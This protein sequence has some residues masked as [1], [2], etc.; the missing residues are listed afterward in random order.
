M[1][2][3][4]DSAWP[5]VSLGA[6]CGVALAWAYFRTRLAQQAGVLGAEQAALKERLAAT[7]R[8]RDDLRRRAQDL[9]ERA[10]SLQQEIG[11]LKISLAE[12]RGAAAEKLAIV[13]QAGQSLRD[14]FRALSAETL[15]KS[16]QAFLE[17]AK[18]TFERYQEGARGELEQRQKAI[19]ELVRPL[20]D[21]LNGVDQKVQELEK[22]RIGAYAQL[23]E[24]VKSL[25][26]TQAQ[27]YLET[28]QLVR[29]L[30]APAARG[31]WGEIQLQRV[32]EMAGMLEHCDFITQATL[33][34]DGEGHRL[35]PDMVVRLPGKKHV[36]VD[37]KAPLAAYLEALEAQSDDARREKL[38][39]HARQV[40]AHVIKLGS[41]AYWSHLS[42][43]PEFVVMFLPGEPF[44]S[45]ALEH[46]PSLI[47]FGV[48]QRVI[49]ATPTTLIALLRAVAYGWRQEQLAR[50]AEEISR[51]G[52][53]LYD[54]LRVFSGHFAAMRKG[55]EGTVDAYNRAVGSLET[56]VLVTARRFR[57]L[58]AAD[59]AELG[60]MEPIAAAPR[61]LEGVEEATA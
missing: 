59:G 48:D 26:G 10:S 43:T 9:E 46:D 22:A 20:K 45:A 37:A 34:D 4:V 2:A 39:E 3:S 50:N 27:L 58:G 19:E 28:S 18:G 60:L 15:Q 56:R 29:A 25:A 8:E 6:A 53:E 24:Q 47:E 32:V 38:T 40:R 51:L 52:R 7:E 61:R 12:E 49:V 21:S 41:K 55:I 13:E 17:L 16:Q 35:R 44:F 30:R 11:G 14:A 5:F 31:R 42:P 54:R 36:V 1:E 57:D 23:A 33:D